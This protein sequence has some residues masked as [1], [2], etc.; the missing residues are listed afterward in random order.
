MDVARGI[1]YLHASNVI[2]GDIKGVGAF[3]PV[4]AENLTSSV[5]RNVLIDD[6][7]TARL[8]DFGQSKLIGIA[9]FTAT[10]FAGSV[11]YLAPELLPTD[12]DE[13]LTPTRETDVYAFSMV[14]LEVCDSG[15]FCSFRPSARNCRL[16]TIF[17]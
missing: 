13:K 14:A 6:D 17:V 12:S 8:C 9:G 3:H 15:S 10:K 5:Q 4:L 11:R 1:G 2:H 16:H 7:G